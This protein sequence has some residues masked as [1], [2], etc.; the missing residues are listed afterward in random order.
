LTAAA[1][2]ARMVSLWRFPT[3]PGV[4]VMPVFVT[5]PA[6]GCR[7]QMTEA[8]IGQRV[9]CI[10]CNER[11]LADPAVKPPP[12]P[13]RRPPPRPELPPGG[14]PAPPR[15]DEDELAPDGRPFCPGCGRRVNW[16][17]IVC[18]HCGEPF[19]YS[20]DARR[21]ER[22][23]LKRPRRDSFPHRGPMIANLGN[24]ALAIGAVSLCT[25]GLLVIVTVPLAITTIVMASTDLNQMRLSQ[26]DPAGRVQTENGR[27]AAITGLVLSLIFSAGWLLLW[28]TQR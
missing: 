27:T 26:M 2:V 21:H 18:Y 4:V 19:D 16:D 13:P 23:L 14:L 28:L 7:V 24:I 20:Q 15:A 22:T 12:P 3:T 9:R 25:A 5:C 17:W 1:A 10:A 11:F 8:S 6:C